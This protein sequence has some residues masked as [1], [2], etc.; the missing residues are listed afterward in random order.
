MLL[1][2]AATTQVISAALVVKRDEPDKVLKVQQPIYF[3]SE[4]LSDSKTHCPQIQKLIYVVLIFKRKLRHYFDTHPI[5]V[6]CKYPL[7]EVIQSLEAE[8]RIAKWALE[9]MGQS[10]AYPPRTAI[11]SQVLPDFV[12]EWT[13]IQ[14]PAAPIEH[15]TW[16][17]YF[18]GYLTKEGGRAGLIFI[19]PLG[20]R[21]EYM[22]R[23]HFPVSNNIA[24]YEALLNGLKVTLAIGV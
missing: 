5:M 21:M 13:E 16:T 19:S 3:V 15:E 17:M 23:L 14:T 12:A 11:K 22:I 2:I 8:E 1:Y 6:V 20:V 24:E 4:V 7:K 10:I 9:L 18:D